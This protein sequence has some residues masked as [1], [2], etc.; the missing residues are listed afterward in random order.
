[1]PDVEKVLKGLEC[2]L[3]I[4][5]NARCKECGYWRN[6]PDNLCERRLKEDALEL[7]KE[8]VKGKYV[9]CKVKTSTGKWDGE[10]CSVCGV[11]FIGSSSHDWGFCPKCGA[12]LE[13]GNG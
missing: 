5:D 13:R 3:R 11:Q 4:N 12:E 1:M 2:C 7:L 6:T 9:P 10:K 8:R